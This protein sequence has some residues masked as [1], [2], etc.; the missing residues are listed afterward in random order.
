MKI[1]IFGLQDFFQKLTFYEIYV[2]PIQ[3]QRKKD[4]SKKLETLQVMADK[5]F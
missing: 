2:L 1:V 4:N 3:I 5:P